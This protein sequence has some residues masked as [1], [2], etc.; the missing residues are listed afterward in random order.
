MRNLRDRFCYSGSVEGKLYEK[1]Q[2]IWYNKLN[3]LP[4][5]IF[6]LFLYAQIIDILIT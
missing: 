2:I 1:Y 5:S 6:G 4:A 3:T